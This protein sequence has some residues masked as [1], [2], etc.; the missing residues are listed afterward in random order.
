MVF[1]D[2]GP[3]FQFPTLTLPPEARLRL[4]SGRG[5]DAE[6]DL[7]WESAE[8]LWEGGPVMVFLCDSSGTVVD[9]FAYAGYAEAPS[10]EAE[11]H[12]E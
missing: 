4:H 5:A 9:V 3:S 7:Y 11:L 6:L 10:E 2:V 8:N 1:T 12:E